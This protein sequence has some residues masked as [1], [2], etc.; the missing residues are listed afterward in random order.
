MNKNLEIKFV[1]DSKNLSLNID[2][3]NKK[4]GK[5]NEKV[6]KTSASFKRLAGATVSFVALK[7]AFDKSVES[8]VTFERIQRKLSVATG[9]SKAAFESVNEIVKLYGL[10]L[11]RTADSFGSFAASTRGTIIEGKAATKIFSD[12]SAAVASM[13][14][15]ANNSERIFKALEQIMSK[16]KVSAEELRNQLGDAGLAGA[17]GIAARAM[18]VTTTELD[19][20]M[21]TGKLMSAEFLPKFAAQLKKD[22]GGSASE[23]ADS[24][25]GS[26]NK[27]DNSIF[28]ITSSVGLELA[29]AMAS[30]ANTLNELTPRIV[31]A[32]KEIKTMSSVVLALSAPLGGLPETLAA[33]GAGFIVL[34]NSAVIATFATTAFMEIATAPSLIALAATVGAAA[35]PFVALAAVIGFTSLK[36]KELYDVI[37]LNEQADATAE[38]NRLAAIKSNLLV[39]ANLETLI[40]KYRKLGIVGKDLDAKLKS[41]NITT[42]SA[43]KGTFENAKNVIRALSVFKKA[44]LD[45]K[46]LALKPF[47]KELENIG[48]SFDELAKNKNRK[49]VEQAFSKLPLFM[50]AAAASSKNFIASI[51]KLTTSRLERLTKKYATE[52]A[53]VVSIHGEGSAQVI[54]ID[55][56]FTSFSEF[57]NRKRVK[58]FNDKAKREE[59]IE[60]RKNERIKS[61]AI[62]QDQQLQDA[63]IASRRAKASLKFKSA[64]V[65]SGSLSGIDSRIVAQKA[66]NA[67]KRAIDADAF[68]IS[69]DRKRSEFDLELVALGL[70]EDGKSAIIEERR[71]AFAELEIARKDE[72]ISLQDEERTLELE[73]LTEFEQAKEDIIVDFKNRGADLAS[74]FGALQNNI[75]NA[76]FSK[77]F[78]DTKKFA[79]NSQKLWKSGFDGKVAVTQAGL[80]VI[81]GLMDSGNRKMFEAGKVAAIANATISTIQGATQALSLG[82]I[83]GP[84]MAGVVTAMGVA[85]IS[86]IASTKFGGGAKPSA[87]SAPSIPT[88]PSPSSTQESAQPAQQAG[89]QVNLTIQAL[90]PAAI[91]E[92]T[93]QSIGDRLAPVLQSSFDR[94]QNF[95]VA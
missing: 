11:S 57:E 71:L 49:A 20:L 74:E 38:S 40:E 83:L 77:L 94:G 44:D 23:A 54:A 53:K 52:R 22:L 10:N 56:A 86:K 63:L 75:T 12:V 32:T 7:S 85:N 66:F 33:V 13:G 51:S 29:P 14:L 43:S 65:D 39:N 68:A 34:R 24:L 59:E 58:S 3:I 5:M 73:K 27:I 55:K 47:R 25:Q 35:A 16:G 8:A 2:Q 81:S 93:M 67:E 50:N 31:G 26:M 70:H 37:K 91:D 9:D 1:G 28:L 88:P 80:G 48:I 79:D 19:K 18:G 30:F 82:P 6:D 76:N 17:F 36:L 45:S 90:D 95:A 4:L 42:S 21:S 78:G 72:F 41:L 46:I 60:A 92:T 69:Q 84:V 61:F 87:S 89:A 15:D 64:P 62:S